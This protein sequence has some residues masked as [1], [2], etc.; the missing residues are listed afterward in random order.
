MV[1]SWEKSLKMMQEM[2]FL[3][4]L[5]DFEK[6]GITEEV[7]ELLQPYLE[8]EDFNYEKVQRAPYGVDLEVWIRSV[9]A[10]ARRLV[11]ANGLVL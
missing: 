6:D 4:S 2:S 3:Q 10:L 5:S 9:K 1:P 8:M 11:C 7:C